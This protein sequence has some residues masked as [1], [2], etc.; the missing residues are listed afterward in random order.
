MVVVVDGRG[1]VAVIVMCSDVG[2]NQRM[3]AIG[4]D[5]LDVGMCSYF[6]EVQ[7]KGL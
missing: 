2:D 7:L 1:C 3:E 5:L 6:M 4:T